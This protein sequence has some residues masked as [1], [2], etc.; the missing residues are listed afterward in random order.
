MKVIVDGRCVEVGNG[1][2]AL[3][4]A[5][6]ANDVELMNM[7]NMWESEGGIVVWVGVDGCFVGI[8]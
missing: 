2:F 7:V 8:I 5:W 4:N 6:D 1:E 3:E